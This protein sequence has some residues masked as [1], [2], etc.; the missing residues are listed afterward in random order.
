MAKA[1]SDYL[2]DLYYDTLVY[3]PENL[4]YLIG[5]VGADRI[6]LGT[7]YPFPIASQDPVGDALAVEGLAAADLEAVLGGTAAALLGV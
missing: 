2:R 7:D 5:Q 4:A 3:S 6:V 1:P